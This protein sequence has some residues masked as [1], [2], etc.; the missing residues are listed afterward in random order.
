MNSLT[1][2]TENQIIMQKSN[3]I[4]PDNESETANLI[5]IMRKRWKILTVTAIIICGIGLPLIWLLV[6][7]YYLATAAIRVAPVIS[8]ILFGGEEAIPMYRSYMYTQAD[9]IIS[10]RVLQRVVDDLSDKNI[11]ASDIEKP[12]PLKS[13]RNKWSAKK[14]SDLVLALKNAI[15]SN[16]LSVAP[17]DNTELIKIAVKSSNPTSASKIANAFV[18]A[19]M[20]IVASEEVK[21]GDH[22]LTVLENERRVMGEKIERQRKTLNDMA[23][24]F[25]T[26]V[27]DNRQQMMMNHISRMQEKLTELELE[28]IV[29]QTKIDLHSSKEEKTITPEMMAKL[30]HDFINSDLMVQTTA[31]NVA[32]L[33]QVLITAK[34][35]LASTNPELARKESLLSALKQR[36]EELKEQ[37][38]KNFDE[39]ATMEFKESDLLEM[40]SYND[41]LNQLSKHEQ[42]LRDML[43]SEDSKTIE[44]GRKQLAM[45][46]VKEQ[47]D[48]SKQMLETIQKRVG[49]L[50]M[51]RKR[52]ARISVAY[53]ASTAPYQDRRMQFSIALMMAGCVSGM[54][55]ALL[56]N[57]LDV[58]LKTP[59]DMKRIGV[60]I[61]GTTTSKEKIKES[62]W[63]RQLADDYHAICINLGLMNNCTIPNKLAI[64]SAGP[65]EGKSTLAV[66]LA[67]NLAK[68]G[69]KVLLIDGDLRKPDIA[70]YLNLDNKGKGMHQLLAD[71]KLRDLLMH[72]DTPGLAVLTAEPC[73]IAII[74]KL[75]HHKNLVEFINEVSRIFDHVIIDTPPI[76]AAVDALLWSSMVDGV[77]MTSLAGRTETPDLKESIERLK[78]ININLIGIV[79]SNVSYNKVYYRYGH[80]YYGKPATVKEL[81]QNLP[82]ENT[83]EKVKQQV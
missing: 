47:L 7:P 79:L 69:K 20:T 22:K 26:I 55:L 76:L 39:M 17:E 32:N 77:I 12:D 80:D 29:L 44:L 11:I 65:Q 58:R 25:G 56:T 28:R 81:K 5:A 82:S 67:M 73:D 14:N 53:L 13:V 61:I 75:I 41:K 70:K 16:Q 54:G 43:K 66:N 37:A 57:K 64:T 4:E 63:P 36:L 45:Q 40:Q 34:Q 21:D 46:D 68:I 42:Q 2:F 15:A 48:S 10:D 50:E 78:Q 30:R 59:D 8:S 3:M 1:K 83:S 33:E 38:S 51:E 31:S 27:L 60:R 9:L 19:Y 71:F 23:Q 52:L 24:E 18:Q 6:K 49:E 62:M 35:Q 72:A 74:N